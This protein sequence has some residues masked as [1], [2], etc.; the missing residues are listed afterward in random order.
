MIFSNLF[1]TDNVVKEIQNLSKVI[2][3]ETVDETANAVAKEI[4]NAKTKHKTA[5]ITEGSAAE[6]MYGKQVEKSTGKIIANTVAQKVG[7]GILAA[8][9]LVLYKLAKVSDEVAEKSKKVNE[10]FESEKKEISDYKK[11]VEKL[12]KIESDS[13]STI[14]EVVEARKSLMSIQNELIDKYGDE[15]DSID[16]ITKAINN[17]SNAWDSLIQKRWEAYKDEFNQENFWNKAYNWIQG[18]DDNVDQML[19]QYNKDYTI[20][21]SLFENVDFDKQI[22]DKEKELE[23]LLKTAGVEITHWNNDLLN[24]ILRG[25][26]DEVYD[27]IL[28]LQKIFSED[29]EFYNSR[30]DSQ[31]SKLLAD[32]K[33]VKDEYGDFYKQYVLYEKILSDSG[34]VNGY[35]DYF[36]SITDKYSEYQKAKLNGDKK[37]IADAEKEYTETLVK[38]YNDALTN[39]DT[40]VADYFKDMYPQLQDIVSEWKFKIDFEANKESMTN[41]VKTVLDGVRDDAIAESKQ[42]YEDSKNARQDKYSGSDYVGNVD[43]NN[44]PVLI[45]QDGSYSTTST[46]YQE[47]FDE[48][49]GLYKIVHYTPILPDGTVLEGDALNEYIDKILNSSDSLDADNPK[50]GGYGIVYKVDTEVNGEKITDGNLEDAFKQA[51]VW[52]VQMHEKQ[53]AMY[54]D[55]AA[56]LREYNQVLEDQKYTV[57]EILNW[58]RTGTDEQKKAYNDFTTLANAYCMELEEL[59]WLLSEL[60]VINS[61]AYQ[62][63]VDKLGQDY[64]DKLTPED[65]ELAYDIAPESYDNIEE[66]EK[67]LA[68]KKADGLSYKPEDIFALEYAK[69]ELTNL[70]KISKA[71]DEVQNAYK[72]LYDAIKEYNTNGAISIDTLQSIISLGDNWMDYVTDETGALKLDK[73]A[74]Q[75]LTKSRLEDMRVQ[76]LANL[77]SEVDGIYDDI[78][79]KKFLTATNYETAESYEALAASMAQVSFAKLDDAVKNGVLSKENAKA[80]ENAYYERAKKINTIFDNVDLSHGSLY[81]GSDASKEYKQQLDDEINLLQKQL[82]AG[83]ITFKQYLSDRLAL[84]EKYYADGLIEAD[85]YYSELEEYYQAQIDIYDR[86]LSAVERRFD[87]EI[88]KIQETID[89]IEKQNEALELQLEQQD[90]ILSVVEEVY[91][92]QI[93]S[94]EEQQELLDDQIKKLQDEADENQRLLDIEEARKNLAE[95]RTRRSVFLYTETDGFI[96]TQNQDEIKQYEQELED[97]EREQVIDELEK[98]KEAL[99]ESIDQLEEYKEAW[100]EIPSL[101]EQAANRELA[102]AL[103]GQDYEQVILANRTETFEDFKNNYISIQDQIEDNTT[104]I[105]SYNEK[106]EYYEGLKEQWAQITEARQNAL[107]DQLAAEMWGADWEKIILAGREETILEFK[108]MYIGAQDEMIAKA[109]EA[110][111]RIAE[112][113][114]SIGG[115]GGYTPSDQKP[116]V[117]LHPDTQTIVSPGYSSK[118][119]AEAKIG[120]YGGDGVALGSDGKWYVYKRKTS[121]GGGSSFAAV[122]HYATGGVI[123]KDDESFLDPIAHALGEDHMV[124]VKEGERVLTPAQNFLWEKFNLSEAS[125]KKFQSFT[126]DI[127]PFSGLKQKAVELNTRPVSVTYGDINITMNGVNDTQTFAKVLASHLPHML[128]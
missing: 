49:T 21:L 34:D 6:D 77:V 29:S 113:E 54:A 58:N 39:G 76:A 73:E 8:L 95:A 10:Q 116:P 94:L 72:T 68:K 119:E 35:D 97:L 51:D 59:L 33:E 41:A 12:K 27:T 53:D 98:E 87:K 42:K 123:T 91:D 38:A 89:G 40:D 9:I 120:N 62:E 70:G 122:S 111:K 92:K 2:K 36:K 81:G 18:Y 79:A 44:R 124:A 83:K 112:A 56:A 52:D 30:L 15:T 114:A 64:V 121:K 88:E 14:E 61:M 103:W 55:E 100:L 110:A 19:S 106:I 25:T 105:E 5:T 126:P 48:E 82:D 93:E 17:E 45:N 46:A 80:V 66:F 117:N 63:L 65:L 125:A 7:I 28:T 85:E 128:K 31:L 101:R 84:I 78:S 16:L 109:E 47:K 11:E 108:E 24:G 96:Y 57:E 74:L 60:G 99:Q 1:G 102:I 32:V 22:T 23:T 71:I 127:Q 3:G 26:A 115:G 43:I 13:S 4:N 20:D 67:E 86:I 118:D 90:A 50:N 69:D 37:A 75:K 107:D 104:L